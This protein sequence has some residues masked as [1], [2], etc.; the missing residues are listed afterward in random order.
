MA[1]NREAFDNVAADLE[2]GQQ[3]TFAHI[4]AVFGDEFYFMIIESLMDAQDAARAIQG[5]MA[6][7]ALGQRAA[8][9]EA[10]VAQ[11][12]VSDQG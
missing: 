12:G 2:S 6:R 4:G 1:A 7:L 9:V 11:D 8:A 5:A 3:L 10:T